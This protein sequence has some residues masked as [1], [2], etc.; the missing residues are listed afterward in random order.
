MISPS[1]SW[2][3]SL[4]KKR[5]KERLILRES[6][7]LNSKALLQ[8]YRNHEWGRFWIHYCNLDILLILRLFNPDNV[9]ISLISM[10]HVPINDKSCHMDLVELSTCSQETPNISS[11]MY[12][13]KYWISFIPGLHHNGF[14]L[15]DKNQRITS[16]IINKKDCCMM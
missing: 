12:S 10:L 13:I 7:S 16:L 11:L 14:L 9:G 3:L 2:V 4:K 1:A 6:T 5:K 8:N 15:W